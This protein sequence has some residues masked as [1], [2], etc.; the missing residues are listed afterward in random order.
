MRNN[1]T[2]FLQIRAGQRYSENKMEYESNSEEN[3]VHAFFGNV[4]I[5]VNVHSKYRVYLTSKYNSY[6]CNYGV[7]SQSTIFGGITH[8]TPGPWIKEL[9][10]KGI[11]LTDS[12]E[13]SSPVSILVGNDV[14]GKLYRLTG[15]RVQLDSGLVA[16]QT[17]MD[18]DGEIA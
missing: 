13:S 6:K 4:R 7:L 9:K 5:G 16:M 1:L 2:H 11:Y 14:T 3:I 8:A 15:E 12:V 10:S 18:T 17:S